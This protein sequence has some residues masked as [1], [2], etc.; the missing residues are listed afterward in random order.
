MDWKSFFS[1]WSS[2]IASFFLGEFQ[3]SDSDRTLIRV[4]RSDL[5]EEEPI[6]H[7]KKSTHTKR[8]TEGKLESDQLSY[9][10]SGLTHCVTPRPNLLHGQ[11]PYTADQSV[12]WSNH[13]ARR[14]WQQ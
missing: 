14:T 11:T 2:L 13:L 12:L 1:L 4:L 9:D 3:T 8:S 10:R 6:E 5:E 7:H